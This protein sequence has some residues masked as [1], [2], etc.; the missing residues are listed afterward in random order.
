MTEIWDGNIH[1]WQVY[2]VTSTGKRTYVPLKTVTPCEKRVDTEDY[3][4]ANNV[5]VYFIVLELSD[6]YSTGGKIT[7]LHIHEEKT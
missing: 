1:T 3:F 2:R 4:V 6:C 7:N 5:A